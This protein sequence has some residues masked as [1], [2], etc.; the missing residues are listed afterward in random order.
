MAHYV[1][2]G[3]GEARILGTG[4]RVWIRSRVVRYLYVSATPLGKVFLQ[5]FFRGIVRER[6]KFP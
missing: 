3:D 2:F 5:L 1:I 6:R 4:F